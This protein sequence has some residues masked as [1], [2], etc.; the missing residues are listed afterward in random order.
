MHRQR[1][2]HAPPLRHLAREVACNQ[3]TAVD[4]I[5][6]VIPRLPFR[7]QVVQTDNGSELQSKFYWHLDELDIRH[8]YIRPRTPRL[9]GKVGRSHRTDNSYRSSQTCGLCT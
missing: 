6:E 8:V 2:R 7:V 9:N 3:T 5:D 4:F 1:V